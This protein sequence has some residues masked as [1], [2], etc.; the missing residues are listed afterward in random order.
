ME[1][2]TCKCGKVS[3][4]YDVIGEDLWLGTPVNTSIKKEGYGKACIC[5]FCK[6]NY[7]HFDP[8]MV[9][10]FNTPKQIR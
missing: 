8:C 1:T 3:M 5:K 9:K 7:D 4:T 6:Q 2:E 10:I